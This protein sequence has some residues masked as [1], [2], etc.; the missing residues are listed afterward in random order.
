M[1]NGH[2]IFGIFASIAEF[3]RKLIRDCG[4]ESQPQQPSTFASG[5]R[6]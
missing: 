2:L 3:E 5:G 6:E 1:A 4:R